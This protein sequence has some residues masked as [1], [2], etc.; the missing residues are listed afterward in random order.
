MPQPRG[1]GAAPLQA[2]PGPMQTGQP[3]HRHTL[4]PCRKSETEAVVHD[5]LETIE[6][7]YS[8][9]S[10]L[11][12]ELLPD[13]D[14]SFTDSSSFMKHGT[15]MAEYAVNT[16]PKVIESNSLTARTSAQKAELIVLIRV[17]ASQGKK[18]SIFGQTSDMLMGLSMLMA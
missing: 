15:R 3:P 10:D 14:N 18:S 6:A 8:S 1:G 16:V 9:C 5:C 12:E 17:G 13:A 4:A 2:C 7:V 11:K